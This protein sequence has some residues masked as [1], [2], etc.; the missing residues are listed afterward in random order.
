VALVLA[1]RAACHPDRPI[2]VAIDQE[3]AKSFQSLV[4]CSCN[5]S[6]F[7]ITPRAYRLVRTWG[8]LH[9]GR[10]ALGAVATF[11][12][13]ACKGA[14]QVWPPASDANCQDVLGR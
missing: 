14:R 3:I 11:S 6:G 5:S 8:L 9:A 4:G 7:D 13:H 10:S 12:P 1:G 2:A